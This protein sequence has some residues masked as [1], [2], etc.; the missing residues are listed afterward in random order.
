MLSRYMRW[1][2]VPRS[3]FMSVREHLVFLWETNEFDEYEGFIKEQLPPTLKKEL[4]YHIYGRIL[5]RAPFF[6]WMR[7]CEVCLKDLAQSVESLFLSKGDYLFH[8]GMPNEHIYVLL[9]GTLYISQNEKLDEQDPTEGQLKKEEEQAM[10]AEVQK[11][12]GFSIPRNKETSPADVI[13]MMVGAV[14]HHHKQRHAEEKKKMEKVKDLLKSGSLAGSLDLEDEEEDEENSGK[15]SDQLEA[16]VDSQI[17]NNAYTRIE[18]QDKRNFKAARYIQRRYRIKK[19]KTLVDDS[20]KPQVRLSAARSKQVHAP[21]YLG[22]SCLWQSLS[23]W[24]S[25]PPQLYVYAARCETR[26]EFVY[27]SRAGVRGLL[28]RFSP[29]LPQRFEYFRQAVLEGIQKV[30][31]GKKALEDT[32][33]ATSGPDDSRI[34]QATPK[35]QAES[36]GTPAPRINYDMATQDLPPPPQV[37]P[38]PQSL[39]TAGPCTQDHAPQQNGR[40]NYQSYSGECVHPRTSSSSSMYAGAGPSRSPRG[41]GTHGS[42]LSTLLQHS[43]RAP[44]RSFRAAAAAAVARVAQHVTPPSVP[45][46]PAGTPRFHPSVQP[47]SGSPPR[48]TPDGTARRPSLQEPLLPQQRERTSGAR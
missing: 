9:K 13:H 5:R 12:S 23:E 15:T 26:G 24:D 21:A 48:E 10:A 28:D 3:L 36:L 44:T 7:G 14:T 19:G 42:P 6:A 34:V 27:V 45:V 8:V 35:P 46:T 29:W 4:S 43:C 11:V 39:L 20:D 25:G 18:K 37:P 41:A 1:R 32:S 47:P 38:A 33:F 30:E 31:E 40:N 16:H 22:E 17:L 2:A